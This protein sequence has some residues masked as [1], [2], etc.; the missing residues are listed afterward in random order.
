VWHDRVGTPQ[1]MLMHSWEE[2]LEF[3]PLVEKC[4]KSCTDFKVDRLIIEAKAS[5][6]S[7]GQ[8]LR[9]RYSHSGWAI[10][11]MDP[12]K[13]DKVARAYAV[14]QFWEDGAIWAPGYEDGLFRA[15]AERVI[16]QMATFPKSA[17]DDLTDTATMG[18]KYLRDTGLL[19]RK[20]EQARET[21]E[22]L[23]HRSREPD[24]Y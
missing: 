13:G 19:L 18:I 7:I 23:T 2:W 9:R 16:T 4:V 5:G 3:N 24:L 14:T 6:I 8:E 20:E 1:I 17:L 12:G 22:A 15:W 11:L 21:T 10:E